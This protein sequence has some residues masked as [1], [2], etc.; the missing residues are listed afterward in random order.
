METIP[1]RPLCRGPIHT[2]VSVIPAIFILFVACD[3]HTPDWLVSPSRG[4]STLVESS[5]FPNCNL[6]CSSWR[7]DELPLIWLL[8]GVELGVYPGI[9]TSISG[10]IGCAS[11]PKNGGHRLGWYPHFQS[12]IDVLLSRSVQ[13]ESPTGPRNFIHFHPRICP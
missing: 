1:S 11:K 6:S 5:Q 8:P 7:R 10:R 4:R 12:L 13:V 3:H 2:V 9:A